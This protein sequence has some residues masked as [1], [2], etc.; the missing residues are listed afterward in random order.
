MHDEIDHEASKLE[1]QK[2][3]IDTPGKMYPI[4]DPNHRRLILPDA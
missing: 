3:K 4:Y 1:R 2:T